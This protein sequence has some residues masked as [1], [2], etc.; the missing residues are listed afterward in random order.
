VIPVCGSQA[1]ARLLE[2]DD[3]LRVIDIGCGAGQQAEIMRQSGREVT[4]VALIAPADHVGDYLKS[5]IP[6]EP[7]DAIW[8]SHVLEHQPN[9]GAFLSRCFQDLRADGVLAVTV[10]PPKHEIV[11][12]HLSLWNTGLLVYH[13]IVAGFDCRQARVSEPY[14]N[15]DGYDKYNISVIVRKRRAVPSRPLV[16]DAG[17]IETLAEFF[18]LP[19]THGFDG[20]LPAINW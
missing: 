19:V 2:Y 7:W 9:P 11:G 3:V 8:A 6:G 5:L 1:L 12:G 15:G 17:D 16:Y 14:E 20:R 13:L 10:P 18:P 4:T